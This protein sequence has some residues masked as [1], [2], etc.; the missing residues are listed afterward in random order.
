MTPEDQ[1]D[2]DKRTTLSFLVYDAS[3]GEVLSIHQM[4]AASDAS[5]PDREALEAHALRT[6]AASLGRPHDAL[7]VIAHE[8]GDV[9][10]A[11]LQVD[12]RSRCVIRR[13]AK[14]ASP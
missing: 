9:D 1:V 13:E 5:L 10:P 2:L 7:G 6:V 4:S 8:T 11:R 14:D 12:V 3:T